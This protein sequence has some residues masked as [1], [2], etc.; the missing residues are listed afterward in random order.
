MS[1]ASATSPSPPPTRDVL[2][3]VLFGMPAAGKT[4][5]LGALGQAA[6][7]QEHLL[8][9]RLVD[10]SNGLAEL[11]HR[12]YDDLPRRTA[13][14]VVPYPVVFQ[15]F[16]QEPSGAPEHEK[17]AGMLVDCDGRVANDL[18]LHGGDL[19]DRDSEG[20]LAH[21][22]LA[23]D[24]LVLVID[25]SA[26]PTDLDA[27]FEEFGRFLR[28]LEHGRGERSDVG[29]LPAFL[30]LT[31]CDLLAKPGDSLAEWIDQIEERK[32]A[33][34]TRFRAFLDRQSK[35]D[36]PL[37]FGR[38]DLHLWATAVKRPALAGAPARPREPYGVAELF[39][40][41]LETAQIFRRRRW[42]SRRRLLWTTASIMTVVLLMSAL[43]GALLLGRQPARQSQLSAEIEAYRL[44]DGRAAEIR[45]AGPKA[46]LQ[47]KINELAAFEYDAGF[48]DLP[49]NDQNYVRDRLQELRA[50]TAF[51]E[52]VRKT[53]PIADART[54]QDLHDIEQRLHDAEVPSA[55]ARDWTRTE[56]VQE[57][58]GKI[59]DLAAMRR[60]VDKVED[61]YRTRQREGNRLW[62][63]DGRKTSGANTPISWT[64]WLT[65]VASLIQDGQ[66]P[67]FPTDDKVPGAG[68]VTDAAVLGFD[69]V[70]EARTQWEEVRHNLERVR[71]VSLAL[72][73]ATDAS[74]P[75]PLQIPSPPRFTVADAARRSEE[76]RQAYPQFQK[77]FTLRGLPEAILGEVRAAARESYDHAI[78]A[79][80]EVVLQHL[81]DAAP[82]SDETPAR[83]RALA[84]W[85]E[86]P[87]D[88]ES[89]RVLVL[90]L[91]RLQEPTPEEPVPALAAFIQESQ[92]KLEIERWTLE[93]PDDL[94]LRPAGEV[95]IYHAA[96]NPDGPALKL[97]PAG[98]S[99]R[100]AQRHVS[101]YVFRAIGPSSL[102]YRPGE[103]FAAA[104]AM[105][106]AENRDWVLSWV[107]G[108][109]AVYQ[110]EH[111]LREPLLHRK[112]Q[113]LQDGKPEKEV[114][115]TIAPATGVPRI[116]DLVPIVRL[117]D[118]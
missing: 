10:S 66:K 74:R 101:S 107:V 23:A 15:P 88:L 94:K 34:G 55:F 116:P 106:D 11:Q 81:R 43:T 86:H 75:A 112:D 97:A 108:R 19:D 18:L 30:V 47:K 109:S 1:V 71:D 5:L 48:P 13:E 14:E 115:V 20:T 114:I 38:I 118:R 67:P 61:W 37:H 6:Q 32:R 8:H 111:V 49:V 36:A 22:I 103:S 80:R 50:Y 105:K 100:D 90:V 68:G 102:T 7:L 60:A 104:L 58:D 78:A 29:G 3:I 79:G 110:F 44:R 26:S 41:C 33:V 40:Q 52:K 69:R 84:G 46:R 56:A 35:T 57:R 59:R 85:L 62:L 82:G 93:L 73:V 72:G 39:R 77:E 65:D 16:S 113:S 117:S 2:R 9:G 51:S 91:S 53:R 87:S 27:A 99:Q 92:F 98:E 24:T 76:L 95:L 54:D 42:R 63:F 25:A 21:E 31:K 17:L 96:T 83:W 45:L 12:L 28:L 4:S 89:W 70:A 64:S